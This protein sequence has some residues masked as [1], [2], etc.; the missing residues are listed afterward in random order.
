MKIAALA[1]AALIG[2]AVFAQS[3]T[4]QM[5]CHTLA[6]SG[7]YVA[8]DETIINGMACKPVSATQPAA[9]APTTSVPAS[10]PAVEEAKTEALT[11]SAIPSSV[12]TQIVAGS[13]V[14]IEPMNGF[15]NYLAAA[16]LK[17]KVQLTVVDNRNEAKYVI[18]GTAD[19]KKAGW[20]KMAFMGNIHSDDAASITMADQRTG[21]MVFAYAVNKKSTMHGQ[22]TTAEACAK[23]LEE[24]IKK[25]DK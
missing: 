11:A 3:A 20:A 14:F 24:Q 19:E 21:A 13:T 12:S 2:P 6:S 25:E 23:H 7:N 9:T 16:I 4:V 5:Q 15:E 10:A 1:L 18:S 17:K 8:S 22:Q